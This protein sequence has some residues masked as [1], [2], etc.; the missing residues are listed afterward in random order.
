MIYRIHD[1]NDSLLY[2]PIVLFFLWFSGFFFPPDAPIFLNHFLFALS[3]C[4][5]PIFKD[6]SIIKNFF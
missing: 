2:I 6:K 5:L 3:N 4:L 1:K